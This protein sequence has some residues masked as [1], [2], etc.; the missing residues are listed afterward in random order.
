MSWN[1][2]LE[3]PRD[4]KCAQCGTALYRSKEHLVEWNSS[5]WHLECLLTKLTST[6]TELPP[7]EPLAPGFPW[8]L[9][10]P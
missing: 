1:W 2:I 9:G 10:R 6:P 3:I 5:G 4:A 8:G 7:E